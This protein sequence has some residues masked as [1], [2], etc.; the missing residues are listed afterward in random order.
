M[1]ETRQLS[2]SFG[3]VEALRGVNL[4]VRAG[5]VVALVGPNGSGKT[6]LLNVISGF[7][8]ASAGSIEFD[9]R[10][11][12]RLKASPIARLG[13]VRTFQFPAM[14]RQMSVLEVLL[15]AGMPNSGTS[16]WRCLRHPRRTGTEL[17]QEIGRAMALLERVGLQDSAEALAI[18][19]SGGQKK[20]LSLATALMREPRCL[21]LDEPTAGV[22]PGLHD[23]LTAQI[24]RLRHEG[25]TVLLVEH[26]MEFVRRTCERSIVLDKGKIVADCAPS[27]LSA[28]SRVVEAYLGKAAASGASRAVLG[29]AV[30]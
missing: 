30:R 1:L 22:N 25:T 4:K 20:L 6:T 11:I 7:L 17:G 19:L 27:E 2:R 14:P 15:C 16:L 28:N 24:A 12:G 23:R 3:G 26:N 21:L 8:P 10:M 13:L 9:G 5:E 18:R 29:A